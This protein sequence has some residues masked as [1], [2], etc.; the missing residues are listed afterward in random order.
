MRHWNPAPREWW[1]PGEEEG[2]NKTEGTARWVRVPERAVGLIGKL[3][4]VGRGFLTPYGQPIVVER[5]RGGQM[6]ASFNA[7]RDAAGL[8]P[9]V[10]PY[11]LRHT[12]ATWFYAQTRDFGTLMDLGGWTKA[13]TANHYRKLAPADLGSRLLAHGWDFREAFRQDQGKS[14]EILRF[15][16]ETG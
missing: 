16:Q 5:G 9:D 13:D 3:P 11:T 2:A 14:A 8:G 7:A 6:Q 10:V 15:T 1:I 12:W 4:E